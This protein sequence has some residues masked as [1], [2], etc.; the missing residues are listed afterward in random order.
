MA[1]DFLCPGRKLR[2]RILHDD[3]I[4]CNHRRTV[5]VLPDHST[6]T[7]TIV[8]SISHEITMHACKRFQLLP[9]HP[10]SSHAYWPLAALL[11]RSHTQLV[12]LHSQRFEESTLLLGFSAKRIQRMF[13]ALSESSPV[14]LRVP[15]VL[16][17][18]LAGALRTGTG[19]VVV[20]EVGPGMIAHVCGWGAGIAGGEEAVLFFQETVKGRRSIELRCFDL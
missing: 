17:M 12:R 19:P 5:T 14:L 18:K 16:W 1:S 3:C 20:G 15:D 4:E 2:L 7:I 10:P 13:S 8:D 9:S 6:S 11:P